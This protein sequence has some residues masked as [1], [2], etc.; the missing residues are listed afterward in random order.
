MVTTAIPESMAAPG[1]LRKLAIFGWIPVLIAAL[2][3]GWVLYSRHQ[4]SRRLTESEAARRLES[5]REILRRLGSGE[6]KI[7]TFYASPPVVKRGERTLLC[8]GVAGAKTVKIEPP[9]ENLTPVLSRCFEVRPARDTAYS[10]TAT[11]A[12]GHAVSQQASVRVEER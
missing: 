11:D 3:A 1:V 2:Y 8:Y 5:D 9:V 7:L 4:Q 12:Q 6:V 10:L